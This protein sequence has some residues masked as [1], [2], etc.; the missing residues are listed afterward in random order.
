M[1]DVVPV[2]CREK[3]GPGTTAWRTTRAGAEQTP[4]A[5]KMFVLTLD[6]RPPHH[7][8]NFYIAIIPWVSHDS[9]Q[10]PYV[11]NTRLNAI[12]WFSR[13]RHDSTYTYIYVRVWAPPTSF[14]SQWTWKFNDPDHPAKCITHT[15][16]YI[17]V[18]SV[19]RVRVLIRHE[20]STL[21]LASADTTRV[22]RF[23]YNTK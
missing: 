17:V 23:D 7:S 11:Q 13:Y 8:Q 15:Y 19:V 21:S 12:T 14:A 4:D 22:Y 2:L 9:I 3:G 20:K 10:Y 16:L 1:P 18:V 5:R 6:T